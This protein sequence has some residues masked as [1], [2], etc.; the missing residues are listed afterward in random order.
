MPPFGSDR[1]GEPI[2]LQ[3]LD[4]AKFTI[5]FAITISLLRILFGT[6]IGIFLSLY[7]C[8]IQEI[9]PSMF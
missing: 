2:F 7:L 6:C 5:L 1:F 9:F 4:G 3:I 8:K